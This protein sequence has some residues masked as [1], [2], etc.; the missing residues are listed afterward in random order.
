LRRCSSG[1]SGSDA[2]S[3][4]SPIATALPGFSLEYEALLKELAAQGWEIDQMTARLSSRR[5]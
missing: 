2:E 4:K 5:E 3:K 1:A